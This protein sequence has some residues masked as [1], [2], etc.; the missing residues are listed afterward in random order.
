MTERATVFQ[1]VQL[2]V[3]TTKGT[4]VAAT[5]ILTATEFTMGPK[6]DVK[7][8]R[9]SGYRF[10]TIAS[11]SKE[12][13]EAKLSGGLTY[14]EIVYWLSSG[15]KVVTPSTASGATTW[16]FDIAT[17][18][19]NTTKAFTIEMGSAER[20]QQIAYGQLTGFGL[21]FDREENKFTGTMMGKAMTDNFTLTSLTSAAEVPLKP[22]MPTQTSFKIADTAAGLAG[23]TALA[24]GFSAEIN[25]DNL[26]G[27]VYPV[28]GSSSF[29]A[30]VPLIPD[31]SV[32]LFVEAD[33]EGMALLANVRSGDTK[34]LR[35]SA[36]GP[37][38]GAGPATYS[39]VL[40]VAI[41]FTGA[42]DFNDEQ[43]VF[44]IKWSG[45]LAHDST[46]GKAL[47]ITVI[48]EVAGL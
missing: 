47:S 7:T 35:V 23:A 20:A 38:I 1:K 16:A 13:S 48:N 44:A 17:A 36:T 3:E 5:K 21:S 28:N 30:E 10:D 22:V 15:M 42:D 12:W 9:P 46:F 18:S 37:Q 31:S 25:L 34:F 19:A 2:G 26:F 4:A 27:V 6:F 24:R 33:S 29:A 39:L 40:D 14:S 45:K 32:N 43:G 41:K 8:Y 11:L